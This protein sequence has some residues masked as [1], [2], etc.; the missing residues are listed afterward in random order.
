MGVIDVCTQAGYT[1][2]GMS[3]PAVVSQAIK[4]MTAGY[5]KMGIIPNRT[6]FEYVD[7]MKPFMYG[8]PRA[9]AV[10]AITDRVD[11]K[12]ISQVKLRTGDIVAVPE[13]NKELKE[14]LMRLAD[15]RETLGFDHPNWTAA[16]QRRYDELY[17]MNLWGNN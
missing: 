13:A 2:A 4:V 7:M 5:K 12:V 8:V 3:F 16:E 9:D 14:E 17:A 10:A 11:E 1:I 15:R 6:G